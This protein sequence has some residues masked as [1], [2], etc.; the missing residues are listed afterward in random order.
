MRVL[1]ADDDPVP[2]RML[3]AVLT[4]WDY[5]VVV[6]TDGAE[7]W[8]ILQSDDAPPLAILDWL[9]PEIDGVEVCRRMRQRTDA[10]YVYFILL[11]SKDRKEDIIEGMDAGAD[12]YLIKPFDAHRLQVRLRAGRRILDLQAELLASVQALGLAREREAEIGARIQQTLLLGQPPAD[13]Q[14]VEVA[15]LTI[16]SQQIDGDFYD[17][18]QHTPRCLDVIVGDVMGKGV[19]AALFGAAV[20]SHFLRAL[21]RLLPAG[22]GVLPQ[23]EE[24][25]AHVHSEVTAEF[26]GLESYMTL[27]Y[28]RFDQERQQVTFVDCGH[29][30]TIHLVR[31]TGEVRTLEGDSLPLGVSER[32]VYAQVVAPFEEGDLFCFYSDGVTEARNQAGELFGFDRLAAA[33][34]SAADLPPAALVEYLRQTVVDFSHAETFPDDLTC[35]V[36]RIEPPGSREVLPDGRP[37]YA[38]GAA[39]QPASG[40]PTAVAPPHRASRLPATGDA[41][42]AGPDG[43]NAVSAR[44]DDPSAGAPLAW[45]AIE[46][47]SAL[48]ELAT[49]RAFVRSF[50]RGAAPAPLDEARV[51][52]LELAV[53]EAASNI[54][55]HAYAGRTD[56]PIRLEAESYADRIAIRLFNEG[57]A[58][59]PSSAPPPSFDG[60]R[61]GGFG[62]FMIANSVDEAEYFRDEQGW[63][64]LAL[65]KYRASREID[66]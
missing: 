10:P 50:C 44:P 31:R 26:I 25:I 33:V 13:L 64:G 28:A 59:D 16:P 51:G 65:V 1:I 6:A 4:K 20:K 63:N 48:T 46:T 12:D 66:A 38:T 15:A 40:P 45:A 60:T 39:R 54:M 7:A 23:P 42:G 24:I 30:K 2:R 5:E 49:I 8:E 32:E 19:P 47:S 62:V 22:Q 17:F 61:D 3:E 11:T 14:G 56:A 21:S 58:F 55:R 37:E 57:R 27:C 43:G 29:T 52:E 34:R 18:F 9:M 35:V 36:V 41:R 53:N